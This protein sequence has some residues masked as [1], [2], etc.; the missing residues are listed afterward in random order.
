MITLPPHSLILSA[1]LYIPELTLSGFTGKAGKVE[2]Y[3]TD[4]GVHAHIL[5]YTP[6][7]VINI[8]IGQLFQHFKF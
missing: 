2:T 6:H 1:A 3:N 8:A 4:R 5:A 7:T